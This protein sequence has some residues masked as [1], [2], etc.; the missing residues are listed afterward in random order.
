MLTW[1]VRSVV[2][3][4]VVAAGAVLVG[5][6]VLAEPDIPRATLE[7]KYA[8]APSQLVRLPSGDVVHFRDQGPRDR[9]PLVLLHGSN[10]SLHTWE[11]WVAAMP[12]RRIITLDL[13]AHG[14]TGPIAS[15]DY[16]QKAMAG[17]TL[18]T[19]D[20]LGVGRFAL[21]GNSMGGGVAARIALD[22]PERVSHLVLVAAAGL[23][24][25]AGQ[26]RAVPLA[27]Q[28]LRTP[29]VRDVLRDVS[30]RFM[31]ER[32]LRS[33]VANEAII[34]A[35]MIDRYW[36][37]ARLPGQRAATVQR[38]NLPGDRT[39]EDNAERITVPTLILWGREDGWVPLAIGERWDARL[40]ASTLIVYDG[41]G[42]L[43]H[44]EAAARS[45]ADVE[46]FLGR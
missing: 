26:T 12:G 9:E 41:I 30:P 27:F 37:L 20:A 19:L 15:G 39:L 44:E 10:A 18:A 21:G 25:P 23:D 2:A 35:A 36:E 32:S 22:A 14:L 13:Q 38:V 33:A 43:P 24:M 40:P 31:F 17:L 46:A 34:T 4:V 6:F 1:L 28:L 16:G 7:A 3:L 5:W 8:T 42:H 11:P 45:A 29:V